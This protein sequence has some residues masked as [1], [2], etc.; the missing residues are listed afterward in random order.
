MN[1]DR[2]HQATED[3]LARTPDPTLQVICQRNL[4]ELRGK[5]AEAARTGQEPHVQ[6]RYIPTPADV[7][8]RVE[9]VLLVLFCAFAIWF[10]WSQPS[11]ETEQTLRYYDQTN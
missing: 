6:A 11:V 1:I 7:R 4:V 9:A 2:A 5:Q 8:G 3:F 10:W